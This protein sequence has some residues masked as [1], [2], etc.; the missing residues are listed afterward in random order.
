MKRIVSFV[1]AFMLLIVVS[2]CSTGYSKS[3]YISSLENFINKVEKGWMSY[4]TDD[5]TKADE[6]M[7]AYLEKYD[8]Y[9]DEFS[10]EEKQKVIKLIAKYQ[11]IY[12]KRTGKDIKDR[13]STWIDE[14]QE[15]I[16]TIKSII[17]FLQNNVGA[18]ID[19]YQY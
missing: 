17:E 4:D 9:V 5:W 8:E 10:K 11:W 18:T 16:M 19:D 6:R 12:V 13:V 14:N 7:D 2:S 3:S 15:L 1:S